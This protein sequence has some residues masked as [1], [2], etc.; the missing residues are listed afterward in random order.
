MEVTELKKGKFYLWSGSNEG[1]RYDYHWRN[2]LCKI[3]DIK[4]GNVVIFEVLVGKQYNWDIKSLEENCK[5][6]RLVPGRFINWIK[7]MIS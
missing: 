4:D 2:T 6:K 5:F 3:L 1:Y 7:Q